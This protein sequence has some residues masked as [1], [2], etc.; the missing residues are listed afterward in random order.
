MVNF[1][2][3]SLKKYRYV[4]FGDKIYKSV[5]MPD[6]KFWL[7]ENLSTVFEGINISSETSTDP[8]MIFNDGVAYYNGYCIDVINAAVADKGWRVSSLD[9]WDKF[10]E[11]SGISINNFGKYIKT[12]KYNGIDAFEFGAEC[13]GDFYDDTI[14]GVGQ[15]GYFW[16][17][18]EYASSP[19]KLYAFR[20]NKSQDKLELGVVPKN[21][22]FINIRLVS[23]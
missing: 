23:I 17:S 18:E 20:V 10:G 6:G 22:V 3:S 15:I 21:A 19:D 1:L 16:T 2:K 7:A 12:T 4:K 5:R 8:C 14:H 11:A 9:D 13:L